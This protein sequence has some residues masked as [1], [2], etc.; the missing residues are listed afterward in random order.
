MLSNTRR[1]IGQRSGHDLR[2]KNSCSA[3]R[4]NRGVKC[5]LRK[6]RE[7]KLLG[8]LT[9]GSTLPKPC[10][11]NDLSTCN[12]KF[13]TSRTNFQECNRT[14]LRLPLPSTDSQS[15][16]NC[17]ASSPPSETLASLHRPINNIRHSPRCPISTQQHGLNHGNFSSHKSLQHT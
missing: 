13:L 10:A 17:T 15:H 1:A 14:L 2:S 6:V 7:F 4:L 9:C 12:H 3:P 8:Y 5:R 16:S 11:N